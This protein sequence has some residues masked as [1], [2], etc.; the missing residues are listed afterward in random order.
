M[1][2]TEEKKAGRSTKLAV[3]SVSRSF[4]SIVNRR[5]AEFVP[6]LNDIS[7][8]MYEGEIVS[9]VG[10]SGC[11]KTTLLRIVGGLLEPDEGTVRVDGDAVSGPGLDRAI[12]FQ[13]PSLLPWRNALRNV[14]F[15]LE[16]KKAGKSVR[17]EKARDA[18]GLVGLRDYEKYYP[19]QLSGG[20]QQ[21]VGLARALAVEPE[22]LLMDEP[23]SALDAQTREELQMEL[24][25]LHAQTKKTIMF[26]THD[27]D[28]AI[29]LSDRV[30]VLLP[31]PGRVHAVVDVDLPR[32]RANILDIKSDPAFI[33]ARDTVARGIRAGGE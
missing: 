2:A 26:V 31:H 12:V 6:V 29:Y 14:E 32:P 5:R 23:F 9:V 11:G 10:L 19:K 25:D 16:L 21:R 22:I 3:E 30:L 24:L 20:M 15:G 1:P 13:Q 8:T 33:K 17:T 4:R 28:E 18:L 27:L 7:F